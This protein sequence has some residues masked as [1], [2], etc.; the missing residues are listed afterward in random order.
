MEL[1][2]KIFNDNKHKSRL[3]SPKVPS[4]VWQGSEY[5]YEK[6]DLEHLGQSI[7]EWTK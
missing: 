5:V 6:Q 7:Q 3:F 4:D 1:Y 2:V